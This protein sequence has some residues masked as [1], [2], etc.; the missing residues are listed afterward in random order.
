MRPARPPPATTMRTLSQGERGLVL[1]VLHA[2]ALGPADEGREGVRPLDEV[3]DLQATLLGFS[4]VMF[5]RI[6]QATYVEEHASRFGRGAGEAHEVLARP[7][8][9]GVCGGEAHLHERARGLPG[10]ARAQGEAFQVVVREL[11]YA[12]NE[13][14]R[15]PFGAREGVPAVE[16]FGVGPGW[17]LCRSGFRVGHADGYAFD[18]PRRG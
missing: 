11:S 18:L 7:Y 4:A 6:Y 16:R 1:D 5:G 2:D 10:R 9:G 12:V 15:E 8:G 3:G 13:G 14:E 17:K